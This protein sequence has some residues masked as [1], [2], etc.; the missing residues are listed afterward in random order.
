MAYAKPEKARK[1]RKIV[2][3]HYL[4]AELHQ[5][6]GT[7]PDSVMSFIAR[8]CSKRVSLPKDAWRQGAA[9]CNRRQADGK[10]GDKFMD[11]LRDTHEFHSL[12]PSKGD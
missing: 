5:A 11:I 4:L 10:A 6:T 8:P 9:V 1:F 12:K 7:T 2:V 3:R